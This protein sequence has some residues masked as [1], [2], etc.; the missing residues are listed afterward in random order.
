M[1]EAAGAR[2][3]PL[4]RSRRPLARR[5]GEL[6]DLSRQQAAPQWPSMAPAH[7]CHLP[8][9]DRRQALPHRQRQ[10]GRRRGGSPT[11]R[12]WASPPRSISPMPELLSYWMAA[13]DAQ[14]LLR[15]LNEHIAAMVDE[16]GG[17]R[18]PR[19]RAAAGPRPRDRRLERLMGVPASPASRSAATSTA[20]RSA[21]RARSV[22]RGLR[23]GW[24]RR[25]S[26]TPS[27]PPAWTGSSARRRCSRCSR[28]PTD[29]G[30]AAASAHH[31]RHDAAPAR[32]CASPSATAAARWPRCC[33]GCSRAGA[34]FRR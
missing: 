25:S 12:R 24:V 28:Y 20:C 18:R 22:L 30:L 5:S 29:V 6:P 31:R 7:E 17:R 3:L 2:G 26:S 19:R 15:Y 27:S 9:P 21:T 8:R 4:R 32:A 11:C 33:R 10:S 1:A 16:S 13:A 23:S 34:C 14:P